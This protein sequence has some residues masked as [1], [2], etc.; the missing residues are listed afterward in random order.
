MPQ[1][2]LV[3]I[4][5]GHNAL[6]P[7]S[8]QTCPTPADRH[9]RSCACE[10]GDS[11][12]GRRKRATGH[13]LRGPH[14]AEDSPAVG[15][16]AAGHRRGALRRWVGGGRNSGAL[17]RPAPGVQGRAP[18]NAREGGLVLAATASNPTQQPLAGSGQP[19][20]WRV[21][22]G[23]RKRAPRRRRGLRLEARRCRNLC[24]GGRLG[25]ASW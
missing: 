13:G 9:Q 11:T 16:R 18:R 4:T 6:V 23:A 8:N 22:Q 25:A 12:A 5:H 2:R 19:R 14:S 21:R 17:G 3:P 10:R 1:W 20:G 15:G 7:L 24:L